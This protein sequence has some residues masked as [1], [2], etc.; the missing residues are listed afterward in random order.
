VY[1]LG[2]SLI[3]LFLD[4]H[5]AP[6]TAN[7]PNEYLL[8]SGYYQVPIFWG[9]PDLQYISIDELLNS[10]PPIPCASMLIGILENASKTSNPMPAYS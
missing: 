6:I 10:Y 9:S 2:F 4:K 1:S 8:L 3:Y 5:G 7:K